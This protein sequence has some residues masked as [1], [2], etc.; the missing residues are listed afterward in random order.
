MYGM[1]AS[2]TATEIG[3]DL[4]GANTSTDIDRCNNLLEELSDHQSPC[5]SLTSIADDRIG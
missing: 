5:T 3:H 4:P 1:R 2:K